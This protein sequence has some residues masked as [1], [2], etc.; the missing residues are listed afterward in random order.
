MKGIFSN[1]LST[2][3]L[4]LIGGFIPGPILISAMTESLKKI[5]NG[6]K[7]VLWALI[8][9]SIIALLILL[10]L[11]SLNLPVVL[12]YAISIVG[13]IYLLYLSWQVAKIKEVNEKDATVFNFYK[14]FILT[15]LNGSFWIFWITICVPLALELKKMVFAGHLLFL[16][17][18]ELGWLTA[19]VLV[20][21]IFS[22]FKLIFH[23]QKAIS[24]LYRLLALILVYFSLK[25]IINGIL[26]LI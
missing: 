21:L 19:T 9:E 12:F 18:F 13:G 10:V 15:L 22:R 26:N 3:T 5:A 7:V 8:S 25:M 11:F 20:V 1:F 16:L 6:L 4:G 2:F 17:L 14:I 24:I 23:N